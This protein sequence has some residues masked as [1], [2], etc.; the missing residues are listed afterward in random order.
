[1]RD[2]IICAQNFHPKK[3]YIELNSTE[4]SRECTSEFLAR[5]EISIEIQISLI[6]WHFFSSRPLPS[7]RFTFCRQT[8]QCETRKCSMSREITSTSL[9]ERTTPVRKSERWTE[10]PWSTQL[11]GEMRIPAKNL[12]KVRVLFSLFFFAKFLIDTLNG[13][14]MHGIRG[15]RL[16]R[17]SAENYNLL[18]LCTLLFCS[19]QHIFVSS[20]S[21]FISYLRLPH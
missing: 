19:V 12:G 13:L 7:R 3:H 9:N 15:S 11:F 16:P 14:A 10:K 20:G 5:R 8:F 6:F 18:M 21:F 1:M 17:M 4:K 2:I